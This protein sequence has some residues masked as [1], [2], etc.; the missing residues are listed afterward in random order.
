M[1][2][3]PGERGG[4]LSLAL[5]GG[6]TG[7]H[8]VP[9]LHLLRHFREL[10]RDPGGGAAPLGDLLWFVSGREVEE[11]I[12]SKVD[13]TLGAVAMERVVLRLEPSEGGAPSLPRVARRLLPEVLAARR[14]LRRH[15]SDLLLGLGGFTS[16]PAVLAARLLG[17]PVVLLEINA[18]RGRA[19][20]WLGPL[21]RRVFHAWP[22]TLPAQAGS[23]HVHLGPPLSPVFA[24]GPPD[25]SL[26][27]AA[28][29]ELGFS[30]ERPLLLVLGGSQGALALNRF[31]VQWGGELTASGVQV[32]HQV[33]PGRR[34]EG[35]EHLD[36]YRCEEYL[37]D[38]P[39]ALAAAT[40]V[41]C[42][43]GASTLAEV[44]VRG[45]PAVVVPYPH[46][47]DRH[48]ERNARSLGEGTILVSEA[49]LGAAT[50]RL[51][52]E[53]CGE[54]GEKRRGVMS[55]ALREAVPGDSGA[56]LRD[57]LISLAG[58]AW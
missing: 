18:A 7:G 32:L 43:G 17:I 37:D 39:T 34:S 51:L 53:L 40:L 55:A 20:R 9:G 38:I 2:L 25:P 23:R 42:R 52:I 45:T 24:T 29:A 48:Q 36:G 33:G 58:R 49:E 1:T 46:H 54:G 56:R 4:S 26:R 47:A 27:L 12:L 6:G 8:L 14:A 44:A 50:V 10:E 57:E 16:L 15:R 31:C 28:R 21:T 41:L 19:T 3:P 30:P 35:C 11:R 5:A 22:S 13:E